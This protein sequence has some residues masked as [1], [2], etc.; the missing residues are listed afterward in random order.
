LCC[1]VLDDSEAAHAFESF[2]QN[3]MI[4]QMI[5]EARPYFGSAQSEFE[6]RS[7]AGGP[8]TGQWP[9]PE[10]VFNLRYR[11]EDLHR[12]EIPVPSS[13]RVW[14]L[15]RYQLNPM[16]SGEIEDLAKVIPGLIP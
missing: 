16:E 13:S 15:K 11:P 1:H 10:S 6:M 4:D 7:L 12:Y 8:P 2:K 14:K 3:G 5:R 9:G